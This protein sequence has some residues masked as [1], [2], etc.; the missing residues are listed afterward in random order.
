MAYQISNVIS[1]KAANAIEAKRFV[2]LSPNGLVHATASSQN[3]VGVTKDGVKANEMAPVV[4]KGVVEI[5]AANLP[6]IGDIVKVNTD[7]KADTTGLTTKAIC[8]GIVDSQTI[9]VLL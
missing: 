6:N 4:I 1:L 8:V 9:E 3:V 2:S 7:G 5:S